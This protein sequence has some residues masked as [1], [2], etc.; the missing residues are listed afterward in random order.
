MKLEGSLSPIS[1]RVGA[2]SH[3]SLRDSKY[4]SLD[5]GFRKGRDSP[6]LTKA[7]I[8][9]TSRT[10]DSTITT[11]STYQVFVALYLSP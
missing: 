6:R 4:V 7:A 10:A 2:H 5:V 3:Q 9:Y 8:N 1:D 11:Q